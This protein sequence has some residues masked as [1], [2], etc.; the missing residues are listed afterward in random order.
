MFRTWMFALC[1]GAVAALAGCGGKPS[2]SEAAVPALPM[3]PPEG[4]PTPHPLFVHLKA[5][6]V[7]SGELFAAV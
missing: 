1:A 2:T 4:A 6:E 7:M 5:K 3:A